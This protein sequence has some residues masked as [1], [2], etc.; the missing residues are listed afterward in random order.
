MQAGVSAN[1]APAPA[2][3]DEQERRCRRP[4]RDEWSSLRAASPTVAS[5]LVWTSLDSDAGGTPDAA[6]LSR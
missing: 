6:P 1:A 3:D 2:P 4:L 5:L